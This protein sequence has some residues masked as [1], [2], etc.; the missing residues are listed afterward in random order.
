MRVYKETERTVREMVLQSVRCDFCGRG[1]DRQAELGDKPGDVV[2]EVTIEHNRSVRGE[3]NTVIKSLRV[4]MCGPCFMELLP[5]LRERAKRR[6]T[7]VEEE[8]G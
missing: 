2:D 7:Y 3:L 5:V 4:D 6:L 1:I 8:I